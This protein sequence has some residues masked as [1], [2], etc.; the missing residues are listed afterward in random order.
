MLNLTLNYFYIRP[1]S[2]NRLGHNQTS[3]IMNIYVHGLKSIDRQ[4]ANTFDDI[5][6]IKK[7][8]LE[9]VDRM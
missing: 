7:S 9:L 1:V 4:A 6:N 8:K 3:I 2:S 5:I